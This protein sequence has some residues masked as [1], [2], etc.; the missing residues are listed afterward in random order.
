MSLYREGAGFLN[1]YGAVRLAKFYA[2]NR[3]GTRM[4]LQSTW[5]RKII[6]GNHRIGGGYL[7]PRGNAWASNVVWGYANDPH[8]DRKE[9]VRLAG[10]ALRIDDGDPDSLSRAAVISACMVRWRA[11]W[12]IWRCCSMP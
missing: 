12:R 11:M 8:F 7:N 3:A 5:S 1:S 10:L 9:A 4:P 2:D 6:W